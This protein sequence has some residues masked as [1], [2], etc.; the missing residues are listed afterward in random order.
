M[1][2][3]PGTLHD[4]VSRSTR[5][6]RVSSKPNRTDTPNELDKKELLSVL[7][8]FK[9]GSFSARLPSSL[10]GIDGKIADTLNDLIEL[11]ARLADELKRLSQVVG[12]DGRIS[13][14]AAL[15]GVSGAW[16][17]SIESVNCRLSPLL[18]KLSC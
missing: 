4:R 1:A 16:A 15:G 9:K 17:S 14:R 6:A 2:T 8:A 18:R 13:Q 10:S 11:H 7:L 12:E 3:A 5:S